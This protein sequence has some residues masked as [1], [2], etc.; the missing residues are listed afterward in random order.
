MEWDEV[1]WG[2]NAYSILRTG[3]D[4]YGVSFPISFKAFGDYKQPVYVYSE[5]IP[6]TVFGLNPFAVRFPSALYGSLSIL[7]VYLFLW[8]LFY[9]TKKR[10]VLA[11]LAAGIFAISSWSIQFSRIAFEATLGVFFVLA[12]L[13]L[14]LLGIRKNSIAAF[15]ISALAFAL[16]AYSYHSEKLFMPL[17]LLSLLILFWKYFVKRKLLTLFLILVIFLFNAPWISLFSNVPVYVTLLN[18][19]LVSIE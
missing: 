4:E 2:Y 11:L 12:G 7:F 14:F 16:S 9:K 5:V 6:I 1:S 19:V 15:V 18:L 13:Y 3:K 17:L 10:E 8:E